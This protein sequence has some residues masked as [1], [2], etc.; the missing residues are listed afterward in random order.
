MAFVDEEVTFD[1]SASTGNDLSYTWSYT[2]VS[3]DDVEYIDPTVSKVVS[4][5]YTHGFS[6][7]G[8]YTMK[9]TV[10]DRNK[11]T[12]SCSVA[13][14]VDK[15]GEAHKT[16]DTLLFKLASIIVADYE[17]YNDYVKL[18]G[19]LEESDYHLELFDIKSV[20]VNDINTRDDVDAYLSFA[21]AI[22]EYQY[23]LIDEAIEHLKPENWLVLQ[24]KVAVNK[25]YLKSDGSIVMKKTN[26]CDEPLYAFMIKDNYYHFLISVDEQA[27]DLKSDT[28]VNTGWVNLRGVYTGYDILFYVDDKLEDS[29]S[30]SGQIKTSA[31]KSE[32]LIL[33]GNCDDAHD[34]HGFLDD[35]KIWGE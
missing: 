24:A 33:G 16:D 31:A 25:D 29:T 22:F 27:Y 10:E 2:W 32:A 23:I 8:T 28:K 34:F 5:T 11:D 4:S 9:V 6:A 12:D 13:I 19:I 21:Y 15:N 18:I 7:A 20:Y 3:A 30:A 14:T 1:A 26:N 35:V 17:Y